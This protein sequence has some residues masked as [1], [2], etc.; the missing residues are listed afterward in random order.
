MLKVCF[1]HLIQAKLDRLAVN[2]NLHSIRSQK[3]AHVPNG[4]P[5]LMCVVPKVFGFG[6]KFEPKDVDVCC[7]MYSLRRTVCCQDLA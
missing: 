7:E 4:K 2:W 3:Y 6:K 5:D 1:I